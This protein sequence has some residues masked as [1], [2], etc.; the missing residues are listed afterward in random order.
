MSREPLPPIWARPEPPGRGPRAALSRKQIVDVGLLIADEEGLEAV[1][2]RRLARELR[3]G[4][5]SIYHYFQSRDELLDLMGDQVASEMLVEDLPADWREALRAIAH[6]SR[7]A[8]LTHPWLLPTLQDRPRVTPN[9]LRHVEQSA[10][11]VR[12]LGERGV[13]PALVRGIVFAVDDYTI[14]FTLRELAAGDPEDRARGIARRFSD[15]AAQPYVR[16]LLE[17]G[18]FPM[19]S[20]LVE[21]DGE[22]PGLGFDEGLTWLLD[23]FAARHG[24]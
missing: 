11:A 21:P 4:A 13:A 19:L 6:R 10:Q 18:E 17:S 8:F 1:S 12:E 20:Q 7:A 22:P 14:G 24:I 5:M 16:Y 9:L 23:G 3:S 2:M 15:E